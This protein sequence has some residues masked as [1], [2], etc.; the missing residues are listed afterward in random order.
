MSGIQSFF[1][2]HGGVRADANGN[3]PAEWVEQNKRYDAYLSAMRANGW[4][5][6]TF[7]QFRE[8]EKAHGP[9]KVN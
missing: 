8:T 6:Q 7:E 9:Y 3:P 2:R 5:P 1:Q 4:T